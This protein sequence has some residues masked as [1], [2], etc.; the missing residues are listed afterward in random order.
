VGRVVQALE[1]REIILSREREGDGGG[2]GTEQRW[3]SGTWGVK[4]AR[5]QVQ[6]R[7]SAE[8]SASGHGTLRGTC[9]S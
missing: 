8:V 2:A 7:R 1:S 9:F 6:I 4:K 5:Y 3:D